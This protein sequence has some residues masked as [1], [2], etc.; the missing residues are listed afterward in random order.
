M[1]SNCSG[2][3]EDPDRTNKPDYGYEDSLAMDTG[4][5]EKPVVSWGLL[6]V[7]GICALVVLTILV[8]M[9]LVF[10]FAPEARGDTLPDAS[11]PAHMETHRRAITLDTGWWT[12]AH[13]L[14][15]GFDGATTIMWQR[16]CTDRAYCYERDPIARAALGPR[17]GTRRM[18]ALGSLEVAGVA[19]IPDRRVRRVT[20]V[21]LIGVHVWAGAH[22]I[23]NWH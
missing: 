8:L 7:T 4:E 15:A 5:G 9:A 6:K 16:A 10:I 17:P 23:K 22:N 13:A 11:K 3:Y 1:C 21:A 2:D 14:S 20:Q 12:R 19:M 18:L